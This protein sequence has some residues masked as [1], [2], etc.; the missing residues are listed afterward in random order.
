[1]NN[2]LLEELMGFLNISR[3]NKRHIGKDLDSL[4]DMAYTKTNV[5]NENGIYSIGINDKMEACV[6]CINTVLNL[7]N[8]D[9]DYVKNRGFYIGALEKF[10]RIEK[11][12]IENCVENPN[13]YN[14]KFSDFV[15]RVK[16]NVVRSMIKEKEE[17]IYE[18][19][20]EEQKVEFM[21][22]VDEEIKKFEYAMTDMVK[23]V[24]GLN[25]S[26]KKLILYNLKKEL[27]T[28]END[29]NENHELNKTNRARNI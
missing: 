8:H 25:N 9:E 29:L 23:N 3:R 4:M 20:D 24:Q 16:E 5:K 13:N 26:E 1:M 21:R 15:I 7:E 10:W 12:Y 17:N 22:K 11:E 2:H 27:T 28:H 14:I 18:I 19:E 6:E